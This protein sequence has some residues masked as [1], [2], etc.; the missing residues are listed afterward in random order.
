MREGHS[1]EG[2]TPLPDVD[3]AQ[4]VHVDATVEQVWEYLADVRHL[5]QWSG[6]TVGVIGPE[7]ALRT[8]DSFVEIVRYLGIKSKQTYS[9]SAEPPNVMCWSLSRDGVG[10]AYEFRLRPDA[11]GTTL[12]GRGQAVVPLGLGFFAS[13]L[14]WSLRRQLAGDLTRLA[15][16]VEQ[17]GS[18]RRTSAK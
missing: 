5:A 18:S 14:K 9:V 6:N 17:S 7:R 10:M 15:R 12:E 11:R 13:I 3:V 16:A 2:T 8:G 4:S 1:A